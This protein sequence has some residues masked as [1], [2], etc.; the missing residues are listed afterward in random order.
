MAEEA[1][2][3]E[4]TPFTVDYEMIQPFLNGLKPV[5]RITVSQWAEAYRILGRSVSN[6]SGPWRNSVTPYLTTVMDSLSVFCPYKEI[7]FMKGTQIAATSG[8]ENATGYWMHITPGPI[9][10]V[11]PTIAVAKRNSKRRI[12]S[13]IEDSDVLR[14]IVSPSKSRDGNNTILEKEFAGGSLL[15]CGA[16][17]PNDFR[18]VNARFCIF[19]EIDE[20]PS[21]LSDQGNPIEIAK[22]RTASYDTNKKILLI[23]TPTT[24]GNSHIETAFLETDQ[25]Y[26][27]VPCPHCAPDTPLTKDTFEDQFSKEPGLGYQR[28]VLEQFRFTEGNPAAVFYECLHCKKEIHNHHKSFMLPRW[29]WIADAP[30][31]SSNTRIGFHLNAFYSPVGM[32]SWQTMAWDYQQA[33]KDPTKMKT[34]VQTTLGLPYEAEGDQPKYQSLFERAIASPYSHNEIPDEVCFLTAGADVQKD[35]I[36]IEIVGWGKGKRSYSIDYRVLLGNPAENKVWNE[37]S[38]L[39]SETWVRQ[40]DGLVFGLTMSLIDEGYSKNEV[41]AF[42]LQQGLTRILPS[43]GMDTQT[44]PISNP[45]PV[46]ITRDGKKSEALKHITISTD[47]FKSAIYAHLQLQRNDETGVN[48]PELYCHFPKTYQLEHYRRLTAEKKVNAPGLRGYEKALWKKEYVRNEQ[49]DCRVYA[50]AAAELLGLGRFTDLD[51]DKMSGKEQPKAP[52]IKKKKKGGLPGL[53]KLPEM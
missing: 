17:S 46:Y 16:N 50:M 34:F 27:Y 5:R 10:I 29:K 43:K 40:S 32:Y 19:D 37:L 7:V 39:L 22:K 51:Y 9:L 35:R 42:C 30:E 14:K 18:S 41:Y 1:D 44:I 26:C 36:E 38:Q 11:F 24:K 12:K 53:G 48:G 49:L 47:Y 3:L 23:S 25:N 15:L 52:V 4:E 8:G 31:M 21:D 33:L 20:Y 13:L 28:L 2:L 45:K 6:M